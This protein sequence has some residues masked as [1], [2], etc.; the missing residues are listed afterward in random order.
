MK[1]WKKKEKNLLH[2]YCKKCQE[3]FYCDVGKVEFPIGQEEPLFE[4]VIRCGRCKTHWKNNEGEFVEKFELTEIGQSLLTE[5]FMGDIDFEDD[6]NE[7]EFDKFYKELNES[8]EWKKMLE[9][10]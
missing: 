7:E 2:F 10:C 6:E 4:R 3:D 1:W 5:L 8:K 9:E